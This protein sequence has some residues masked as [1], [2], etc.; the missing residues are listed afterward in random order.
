MATEIQPTF[1]KRFSH[2]LLR[3]FVWIAIFETGYYVGQSL[4]IAIH[5][6]LGRALL[7][8]MTGVAAAVMF[9]IIPAAIIACIASALP[10]LRL[11]PTNLW[12][13]AC[14]A[15]LVGLIF[16]VWSVYD[17]PS[18]YLT[19]S[20]AAAA[21]TIPCTNEAVET[22]FQRV[23]DLQKAVNDAATQPKA[24]VK[25]ADAVWA[26]EPGCA[27]STASLS[28]EEKAKY[29]DVNLLGNAYSVPIYFASGQ[30]NKA[31]QHLDDYLAFV[32]DVRPIAQAKG[33]AKWLSFEQ[34]LT[35]MV[36]RFNDPLTKAGYPPKP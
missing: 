31:R 1:W 30:Y 6:L 2:N 16:G 36:K 8:F 19:L 13:G 9:A 3:W 21:N 4:M 11:L 23:N 32:Q 7:M 26:A 27:D 34:R 10:R 25:D 28:Q 29:L 33:W 15:L 35:P 5:G 18:Q 17:H 20:Q 24:L 22:Q 12:M 14:R